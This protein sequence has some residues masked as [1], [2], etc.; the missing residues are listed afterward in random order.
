[1]AEPSSKPTSEEDQS[2]QEPKE[3]SSLMAQKQEK[4]GRRG[5]RRRH[6][7]CGG[8]S[9]QDSF[10]TYFP[11]ALKQVHL[12]LSLSPEALSVMDSMIRD[13][14]DRIATEAGQLARYAKRVTITPWDIQIAVRL[15]LPGKMGK[16]A[17]LQGTNAVLRYTGASELPQQHLSTTETQRFCSEPPQ[18]ARKTSGPLRGEPHW[19]LGWVTLF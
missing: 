17:E 13:I 14:L 1:M 19:R 2:T 7:N 4:R 12:G 11:S 3:A 9:F 6:A 10:I 18:V 8:D 5:S 15:L 16:S